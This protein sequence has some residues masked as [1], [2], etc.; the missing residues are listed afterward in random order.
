MKVAFVGDIFG[1]PI[2]YIFPI[3]WTLITLQKICKKSHQSFRDEN[4]LV[5]IFHLFSIELS[6]HE[7][8]KKK[9]MANL[10]FFY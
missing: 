3:N 7:A 8:W 1:I 5:Y 4:K 9:T 6:H 2:V 10:I